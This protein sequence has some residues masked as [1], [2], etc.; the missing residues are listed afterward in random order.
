MLSSDSKP[1]PLSSDANHA[2][3]ADTNSASTE[4]GLA[5]AVLT[6]E[7]VLVDPEL[8]KAQRQT[9]NGK[10]AMSIEPANGMFFV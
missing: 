9:T 7:L 1:V 8:A 3:A 5:T 2:S 10:A 4:S 6:P